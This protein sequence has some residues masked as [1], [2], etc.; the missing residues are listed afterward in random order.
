MSLLKQ[1]IALWAC[2][3][4]AS[5]SLAK[6]TYTVKA[7]DNDY[8]IARRFNLTV[9]QLRKLNPNVNWD[10]LPIGS[11]LVISETKKVKSSTT[12]A[13]PVAGQASHKVAAG[14]NSW[15]IAKRYDISEA[16][17]K[18]MN[19]DVSFTPLHVGSVLKV[20]AQSPAKVAT[21]NSKPA[22][23]PKPKAVTTSSLPI[24]TTENVITIKTGVIVRGAPSSDSKRLTL[25]DKNT[26]A[27]I[28]ERKGDWYKLQFNWG[29]HGWVRGDMLAETSKEV[30][31]QKPK[32][33]RPTPQ[34]RA[35]VTSTPSGRSLLDTAYN[36]VGV[37]YV[38]GG[39]SRRGFDCS[40][41]VGYVFRQH[42]VNLPRTA[43]QQWNVG[44]SVSRGSLA[45][46]DLV[47][48]RTRGSRISHVG[49]YVG[50]NRFI[51]ASSGGG[52]IRVND[53]TG[54]YAA[55][56]A[57]ARRVSGKFTVAKS[58]SDW[59]NLAAR[60]REPDFD[61][62]PEPMPEIEAPRSNLG[63]DTIIR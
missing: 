54:Y 29:G 5:V 21:T 60:V 55:R 25:V 59:Q 51:H 63:A 45:P 26:I 61:A 40:G 49:I 52:R 23:A 44:S 13:A 39:T 53:L 34:P 32:V 20:P 1:T 36:Q 41:F 62:D 17:L 22:A 43:A 30:P 24:L 11:T 58:E 33:V 27:K 8:S 16:Q 31:P 10:K 3:L 14:E 48:F 18:A 7:G 4:L 2:L 12:P 38:Y 28:L 37:R 42:G 6:E 9:P 35:K 50:N 46:G 15:T 47:F 57:G 56:Y 19:P